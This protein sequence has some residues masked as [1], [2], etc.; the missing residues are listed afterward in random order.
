MAIVQ[1]ISAGCFGAF[2]VM[3]PCFVKVIIPDCRKESG[4]RIRFVRRLKRV[5]FPVRLNRWKDN[6]CMNRMAGSFIR[7]WKRYRLFCKGSTG[8]GNISGPAI[9]NAGNSWRCF[10]FPVNVGEYRQQGGLPRREGR[11][12]CPAGFARCGLQ[13]GIPLRL[14]MAFVIS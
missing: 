2:P 8:K 1:R 7:R 14:M 10:V 13:S 12:F 4:C 5:R 11:S 6:M 9:W 3:F